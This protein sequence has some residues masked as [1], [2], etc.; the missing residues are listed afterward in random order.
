[1]RRYDRRMPEEPLPPNKLLS[2]PPQSVGP[3]VGIIIVVSI[4]LIGGLYLG[5]EQL[6]K[7]RETLD[8][9]RNLPNST[10]TITIITISMPNQQ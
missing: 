6:K 4:L 3:I 10:T 2:P 1:M 8:R 7:N 5:I 9:I